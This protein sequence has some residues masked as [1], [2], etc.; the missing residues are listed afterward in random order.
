[1]QIGKD[2]EILKMQIEARGYNDPIIEQY[3][4]YIYRIIFKGDWG[5]GIN[6]P[7]FRNKP[8]W[9]TFVTM[10]PPTILINVYSSLFAVPL[11]ILLGI[12]AALR[13]NKWQ[14]HTVS[15]LVM[16]LISVPGYVIAFLLQYLLCFKL[17]IFPITMK[18]GYDYFSWSMFKSMLPA[19]LAMSFGS[20]AGYARFTRAE[21]TEILTSE[22]LLLART[23]GLTRRQ[24]I[25]RHALRNAMVPIFPSIIGEFISVL[26]GSLIIEQ[27]FSI[28]GVGRLYLT[29]IN[30]QD[31]DFFMMLSA[32]YTF[33]G[34]AAGIV[35]DISYGFIDPRIRMGAR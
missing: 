1:V 24:S 25:T 19:V 9:D 13:K 23:K 34:L 16:V 4:R 32:F 28:P 8:V 18:P 17:K 3:F 30:S 26:S 20:I 2:A 6:M 22:Y 15:T 27:I 21:L 12:Y 31:Y 10:L 11:G 35:V 33:I 7:E 5:I 29:A 14:D